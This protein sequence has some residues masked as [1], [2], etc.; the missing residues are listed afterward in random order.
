MVLGTEEN[1]IF[2]ANDLRKD[3]LFGH[4][5]RKIDVKQEIPALPPLPPPDSSVYPGKDLR[6]R[7]VGYR[8]ATVQ[9]I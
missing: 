1:P 9:G 5:A 4:D 3:W 7:L 2:W 6:R 8:R